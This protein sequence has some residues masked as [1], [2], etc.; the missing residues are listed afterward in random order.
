[1]IEKTIFSQ[2]YTVFLK[3]LRDTRKRLGLTQDDLAARLGQTQSF[4]SKCERG[5]RRIDVIELY[6]FCKALQIP[7]DEFVKNL[8]SELIKS[9]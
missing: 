7:F 4:I 6:H 9:D 5:E 1:M 8:M 3:Y 2:E